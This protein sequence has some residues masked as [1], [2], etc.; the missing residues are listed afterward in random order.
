LRAQVKSVC[1]DET[2][3]LWLKVVEGERDTTIITEPEEVGADLLILG[4]GARVAATIC[5]HDNGTYRS[6]G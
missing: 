5:W 3:N 6:S 4:D 2:R 1:E